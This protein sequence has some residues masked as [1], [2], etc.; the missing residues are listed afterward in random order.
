[1]HHCCYDN[2]ALS[3]YIRVSCFQIGL[4]LHSELPDSFLLK[5]KAYFGIINFDPPTIPFPS[6]QP[7]FL[8]LRG[9]LSPS[10]PVAAPQKQQIDRIAYLR[11][12][13]TKLCELFRFHVRPAF[14]T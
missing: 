5:H 13:H 12:R 10:L 9:P 7:L 6:D 4:V 2:A 8:T 14:V 3:V 11:T 1:M